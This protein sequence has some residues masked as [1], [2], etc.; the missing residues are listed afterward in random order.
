MYARMAYS[1]GVQCLYSQ[2]VSYNEDDLRRARIGLHYPRRL[3]KVDDSALPL[4]LGYSA[5]YVDLLSVPTLCCSLI[6]TLLHLL[7]GLSEEISIA[8]KSAI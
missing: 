5:L 6:L 2:C 3:F 1:Y 4:Y 8:N 7:C